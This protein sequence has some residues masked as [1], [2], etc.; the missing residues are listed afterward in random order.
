MIITKTNKQTSN[1]SFVQFQV[2]D[3]ILFTSHTVCLCTGLCD[4]VCTRVSVLS[5]K[6][7]GFQWQR[8][9]CRRMYDENE[10][11]SDVEE[12]TNIRGFSVEEK[13]ASDSYN[14]NFVCQMEG[15]GN[16]ISPFDQLL[17]L[18]VRKTSVCFVVVLLP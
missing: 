8:S 3:E 12:I 15:K 9:I 14:A 13:L 16:I 11:L 4:S 2:W 7:S 10:D 18:L 6:S 1:S 17:P 5:C